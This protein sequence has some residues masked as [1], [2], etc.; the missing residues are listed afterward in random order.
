[1]RLIPR[2]L[3]LIFRKIFSAK[4][5]E[6][7]SLRCAEPFYKT[8]LS[9]AWF[10]SAV[11]AVNLAY[12]RRCKESNL[13]ETGFY[14]QQVFADAVSIMGM[15]RRKF[16]NVEQTR[17]LDMTDKTEGRFVPLTSYLVLFTSYLVLP[18]YADF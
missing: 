14:S 3:V 6:E 9:F 5:A 8:L 15:S 13:N 16:S 17:R 10:F 18:P 12:R 4:G 1:M 2:T 7:C 11:S